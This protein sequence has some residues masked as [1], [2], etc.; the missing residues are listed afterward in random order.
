MNNPLL[1]VETLRW[2]RVR[3]RWTLVLGGLLTI[4]ASLVVIA[5]AGYRS[6]RTEP[7]AVA[8]DVQAL[9]VEPVVA[10][11]ATTVVET[12]DAPTPES[13]TLDARPEPATMPAPELAA[14]TSADTPVTN[15][16]ATNSLTAE[17][18]TTLPVPATTATVDAPS[19]ASSLPNFPVIDPTAILVVNSPD[20]GGPVSFLFD[21]TVFTLEPGEF[22]ALAACDDTQIVYHKGDELEDAECDCPPGIYVFAASTSG[23]QLSAAND[24]L[25][26]AMLSAC[27][28]A[29]G[30]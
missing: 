2:N 24:L 25:G 8:S 12:P 6:E 13:T 14:D 9:P 21:Q 7:L 27:R 22:V 30:Q 11:V 26:R 19:E 5:L 17:P 15:A 10:V 1:S 29:C 4:N 3:R 16:L 23:W 18:A 28:Q 20:N